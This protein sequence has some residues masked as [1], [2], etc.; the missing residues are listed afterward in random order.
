[1]NY[2]FDNLVQIIKDLR[3]FKFYFVTLLLFILIA[4]Y[5]IRDSLTLY[6]KTHT[7]IEFRECRDIPG[8]TTA[9]AA[10]E[11]RNPLIKGYSIY[12]FQPKNNAIYKRLVL[13]DDPIVKGA[14]SMQGIYLRDEPTVNI[15]LEQDSYYLITRD[16][17]LKHIDT[18][19]IA[20]LN[21]TPVLFYALK[22]NNAVIGEINLR[23]DHSPTPQELD[24]ILKELSPI[25]YNYVV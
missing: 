13:T 8:V 7:S 25:L 16:E 6:V 10:I 1:M 4:T 19:E 5:T 11:K 23:L 18:Q 21:L 15:H 9:M 12:L 14:T 2:L 17:A 20:D 3:G 22:S 24:K